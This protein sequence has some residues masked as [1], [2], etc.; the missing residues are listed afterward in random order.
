[1]AKQAQH[2][3]NQFFGTERL[4]QEIERT[5]FQPEYT[6]IVRAPGAHDHDWD[7]CRR[8]LPTQEFAKGKAV[9]VR[10]HQVKQHEIRPP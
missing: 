9:D 2:P 7:R 1:V 8:R 4:G 10:K 6:R 5:Q 3:R